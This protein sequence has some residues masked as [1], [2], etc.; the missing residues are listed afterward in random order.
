MPLQVPP[1]DL[2]FVTKHPVYLHILEYDSDRFPV[3]IDDD[4]HSVQCVLQL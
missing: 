4:D 2:S 1:V 3:I